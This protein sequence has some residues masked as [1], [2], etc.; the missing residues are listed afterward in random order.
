MAGMTWAR[1]AI[2]FGSDM[3]KAYLQKEGHHAAVCQTVPPLLIGTF[4]QIANMPLV[5]STI[6]I[7][8]PKCELNTVTEALFHIYRTKGASGLWHGVSAGIFKTVPKYITA[9]AVKDYMEEA[10]PLVDPSD[11]AQSLLRAGIKSVSAG[12]AGAVLTNPLD[13]LRNE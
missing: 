1:A 12:V 11:K 7:Q 8:D 6:T 9:V 4:V 10:L 13:V 5:R 3:G 2:F